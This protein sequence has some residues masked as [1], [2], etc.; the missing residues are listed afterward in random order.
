MDKKDIESKDMESI[1]FGVTEKMREIVHRVGGKPV[2]E[3]EIDKGNDVDSND[4]CIEALINEG[5]PIIFDG[6]YGVLYIKDHSYHR[7]KKSY[8]M[9][10]EKTPNGCFSDGRKVHFIWCQT[11]TSFEDVERSA[12]YRQQPLMRDTRPIDLSDKQSNIETRL[13]WCKNCI[14]KMSEDVLKEVMPI[15][16]DKIAEHGKARDIH[17]CLKQ[18]TS[19]KIIPSGVHRGTLGKD[20]YPH[21]WSKISQMVREKRKY[22]CAKCDVNCSDKYHKRLLDVD[23]IDRDK[24][25]NRFENLQCLCKIC[26]KDKHSDYKVPEGDLELLRQLR[27]KQNIPRNKWGKSK[28]PISLNP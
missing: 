20:V 22:I 1:G 19:M 17:N 21:N 28:S 16:K 2:D 10:I 6:R 15:P 27:E 13:A 12:R 4:V 5:K 18:D 26:H 14:N 11:L 23:H 25:N 9:Y 24:S 3:F 8:L 7:D